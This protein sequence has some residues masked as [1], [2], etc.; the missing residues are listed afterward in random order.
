MNTFEKL[1]DI[2]M[3]FVQKYRDKAISVDDM[4]EVMKRIDK[5][6]YRAKQ[7]QDRKEDR[8]LVLERTARRLDWMRNAKNLISIDLGGPDEDT[9]T[10]ASIYG[11]NF[12]MTKDMQDG[13][14]YQNLKDMVAQEIADCD[15]FVSMRPDR[16]LKFLDFPRLPE[17]IRF[18]DI[19]LLTSRWH[20]TFGQQ[21]G[22]HKIAE[23]LGFTDLQPRN[24]WND[25]KLQWE[26]AHVLKDREVEGDWI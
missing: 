7:L 20:K 11:A 26:V 23:T 12:R 16:I 17:T 14:T 10:V 21:P 4:K 2:R 18:V 24:A 6:R 25:A 13:Y 8:S 9:V 15:C 22:L 3:S 5:L 1:H 19:S